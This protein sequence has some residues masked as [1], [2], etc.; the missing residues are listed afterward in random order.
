MTKKFNQEIVAFVA[1]ESVSVLFNICYLK[2]MYSNHTR[3]SLDKAAA[4]LDSLAWISCRGNKQ[5]NPDAECGPF[6]PPNPSGEV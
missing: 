6:F 4:Q 1:V 5:T 3:F 2:G